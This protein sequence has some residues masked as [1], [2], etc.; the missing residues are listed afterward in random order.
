[1][2]EKN[3]KIHQIDWENVKPIEFER[4]LNLY[5]MKKNT[6][7]SLFGKSKAW[8]YNV[9]I[10]KQFLTYSEVKILADNIGIETFN[11]LLA[12]IRKQ[13]QQKINEA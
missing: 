9:L 4:V 2:N 7:C 10:K 8:W 5:G 12:K 1:M 13:H 11:A 3:E 6:Y